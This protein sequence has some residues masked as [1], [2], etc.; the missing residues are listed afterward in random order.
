MYLLID[1]WVHNLKVSAWDQIKVLVETKGIIRPR[2]LHAL[3][4]AP[5]NLNEL[6]KN[7]QLL[8]I[9]R[10]LY[11]LPQ[12]EW[13]ANHSLAEVAKAVPNGVICLLSA[14]RF[15]EVGTQSP[16]EVWLAISRNHT[17]APK[18][19]NVTIRTIKLSGSAFSEGVEF[20]EI[21]GIRVPIYGIAKTVVDCWRFRN[22][23]GIDVALEA[24]REVIRKRTVTLDQLRWYGKAGR[25]WNVM[26]PYVVALFI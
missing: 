10:G 4:I 2:D 13:T 3:G 25:V 11:T 8:R 7:G 18:P 23:I 20:H 14:L 5:H 15:H 1:K 26:Q 21:E 17:R 19:R 6:A 12:H 22:R 9:G 24:L 16:F